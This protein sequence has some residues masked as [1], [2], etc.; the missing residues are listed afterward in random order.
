MLE[1]MWRT[2]KQDLLDLIS[3]F[4]SYSVAK[5][6]SPYEIID[7]R[8]VLDIVKS[9]FGYK[10]MPVSVIERV[11][12]R[13]P[14]LYEY[15]EVDNRRKAFKLNGNLDEV[16]S[17]IERRRDE[18]DKK[19][20]LLGEQIAA[21]LTLHVS[22]KKRYEV[23]DG[24]QELQGFFARNG[25]FLGTDQLEEHAHELEGHEEDY[26][27]AQ[28]LYERRDQ[29]SAEYQ[30][31]IDLVKGYFL[32]SAIYLQVENDLLLNSSYRN[33]SFYY[34]TPFLLRLLGYKT[35]EDKL[36]ANELHDAL[37]NQ[38]GT[39][40]FFPQTRDEV[41][42]ILKA[43]KRDIGYSTDVTLEGL[44]EL[45]YS[46]SDVDRIIRTWQQR[47]E[48]EYSTVLAPVPQN[49]ERTHQ[50][51]ID[52]ADLREFLSSRIRWKSQSSMSADIE[53]VVAIHRLRGDVASEDI[54][55]CKA[56]FVTTNTSLSRAFNEFYRS[57]INDKAFSPLITDSDLAALTWIKTGATDDI[58]DTQLLRNA[59]IAC[60][61]TPEMLTKFGQVLAKMQSEGKVS[62]ETAV[63]I[64][65]SRFTKKEVLF[66]TFSNGEG[67]TENIVLKIEGLLR[68]E[69]S[70]DAREDERYKAEQRI[71][72]N[73][74]EQL[75]RADRKARAIATKEMEKQLNRERAIVKWVGVFLSIAAIIG[76]IISVVGA[77]NRNLFVIILLVIFCFFSIDSVVTTWKG[78]KKHIDKCLVER[79]TRTYDRYLKEKA[80]E[81]RSLIEDSKG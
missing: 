36:S 57:R 69:Y 53:S 50:P 78:R 76:L 34:D 8:K 63:A 12:H 15:T 5:V 17:E 65:T 29:G 56:V 26:Y 7:L 39:F 75:K 21:Y 54:E 33:L 10:D 32:Q 47:L 81:Y 51:Q 35:E 24:I 18:C 40:Y 60:Q 45:K 64:R 48:D 16:V 9:E 28:Y 3:P 37:Q 2:R 74:N 70:K 42:N 23:A 38:Q 1:T 22:T 49:N 46:A 66:S 27:I 55:N 68:E 11:L 13:N 25:A 67:I 43:Y 58:P 77:I 79:A 71:K 19:I 14:K 59:Y 80:E 31:V 6:C 41:S 62:Q 61:P 73:Y 4:I 30:Y 52:E 44:D 20:S 72:S